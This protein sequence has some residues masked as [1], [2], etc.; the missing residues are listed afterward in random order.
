MEA[1]GVVSAMGSNGQREVLA[2]PPP[3]ARIDRFLLCLLLLGYGVSGYAEK[4]K[5][6]PL[7]G[8]SA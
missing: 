7:E 3:G 2:P 1:A 8:L 6:W 5:P 4:V